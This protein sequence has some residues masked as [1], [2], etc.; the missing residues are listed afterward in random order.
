MGMGKS[1]IATAAA[2]LLV[3][4]L[5]SSPVR[6]APPASAR[7]TRL[8]GEP[9]VALIRSVRQLSAHRVDHK[10]PEWK[11][12][13]L[14]GFPPL[15]PPV[16]VSGEAAGELAK[17]LLDEKSF[18]FDVARRCAESGP[19]VAFRYDSKDGRLVVYLGFGCRALFAFGYAADGSLVH[20]EAAHFDPARK[21]FVD[22]VKK[23][24][25]RDRVLQK[26]RP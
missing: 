20:V 9:G 6:A 12:A 21:A 3:L 23:A 8:F 2:T 18:D 26:L 25:P 11:G 4:G 10:K 1:T 5:M 17:L 7:V 19:A 14:V 15:A 24:L 16:Q 13:K 22:V